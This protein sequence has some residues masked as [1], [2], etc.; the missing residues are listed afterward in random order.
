[1]LVTDM[2]KAAVNNMYV[3]GLPWLRRQIDSRVFAFAA[4]CWRALW[5]WRSLDG[6]RSGK[7]SR[8]IFRKKPSCQEDL[9][10]R[11]LQ[12]ICV[13][14]WLNMFVS[15]DLDNFCNLALELPVQTL[16][17]RVWSNHIEKLYASI[18]C[19]CLSIVLLA[20]NSVPLHG[21]CAKKVVGCCRIYW[22][23][24]NTTQESRCSASLNFSA[25]LYQ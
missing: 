19:R 20:L 16:S 11:R 1:M 5:L 23:Y 10:G 17:T 15:I 14:V 12:R 8:A 7:T 13:N 24:R 3:S 4:P 22:S 25:Y 6:Y 2:K 18:I 9:L 21:L